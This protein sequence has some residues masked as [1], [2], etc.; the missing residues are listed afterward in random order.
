MRSQA[1]SMP[2]P[3]QSTPPEASARERRRAQILALVRDGRVPSQIELQKRLDDLGMHVNQGTLSR[4]IRD[5]GLLKGPQGYEIPAAATLESDDA[6]TALYAAARTWLTS[7]VA[8][9][10]LVVVKTPVGGANPLALALDR[11]RLRDVLGTIA[12]DDTVFV[13]TPGPKEA[14]RVTEEL[15]QIAEPRTR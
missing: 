2:P 14:R 3:T 6:M 15:V 5:L 4:D 13:A 12:G 8:A 9:Q 11:A 10:N 1:H 7:A